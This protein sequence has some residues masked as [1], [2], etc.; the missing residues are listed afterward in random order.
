[1]ECIYKN[2]ALLID[3]SIRPER[4][5][6]EV[7]KVLRP[8]LKQQKAKCLVRII[9]ICKSPTVWSVF[10]N[11]RILMHEVVLNALVGLFQLFSLNNKQ[12]K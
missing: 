8:R 10:S 9:Q 11:Q 6:I 1:M 2:S 12:Y 5:F 7:I 4:G 3:N